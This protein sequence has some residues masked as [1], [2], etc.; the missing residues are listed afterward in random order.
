MST[1]LQIWSNCQY[2][3]IDLTEQ[4]I[5]VLVHMQLVACVLNL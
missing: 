4:L 5:L 2:T 3:E 1:E